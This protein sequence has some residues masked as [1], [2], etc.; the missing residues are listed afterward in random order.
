MARRFFQRTSRSGLAAR[1]R[2]NYTAGVGHVVDPALPQ[3]ADRKNGAIAQLGERFNGIEEVVGSIPSGS[4]NQ[5]NH[6]KLADIPLST[7][8]FWCA[9]GG[10]RIEI[11]RLDHEILV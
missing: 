4:T 2:L 5:I 3:E 7:D 11:L 10:G 8:A 9:I 6:L 1:F